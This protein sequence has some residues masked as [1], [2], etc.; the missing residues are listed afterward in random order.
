MLVTMFIDKFQKEVK[1]DDAHPL[2]VAQKAK[3]EKPR[4]KTR[5]RAAAPSDDE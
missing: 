4:A 5:S 1:I 3:D 2:A